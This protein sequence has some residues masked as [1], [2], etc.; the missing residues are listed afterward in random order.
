M[1]TV[2]TATVPAVKPVCVGCKTTGK[3]GALWVLEVCGQKLRVHRPCGE[4]LL[5]QAKADGQKGRI[6]ASAELRKQ[7]EAEE[8][9]RREEQT[10]SVWKDIFRRA[11]EMKTSKGANAL[12]AVV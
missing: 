7:R 11:E 10:K 1:N 6:T 2:N 9:A 12:A 4:R 5:T 8:A 3:N